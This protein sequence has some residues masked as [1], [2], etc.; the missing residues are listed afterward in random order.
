MLIKHLLMHLMEIQ[1]NE[2]RYIHSF[3]KKEIPNQRIDYDCGMYVCMVRKSHYNSLHIVIIHCKSA[4]VHLHLDVF[5]TN[6]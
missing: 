3:P 6:S 1:I 5:L 2:F 4:I